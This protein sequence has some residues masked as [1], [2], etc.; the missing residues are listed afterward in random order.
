[1]KA[2]PA[3][4]GLI[5]RILRGAAGVAA[6]AALAVGAWQ[7]YRAVLAQPFRQ[8]VFT[9]D[10]DRLSHRELDALTRAIQSA[11]EGASLA[12]VRDAA[13]RVPWVRDASVR[14]KW[15]DT[16]EIRF[17]THQAFATWNG[18]QLVS[19]RGVV[20]SAEGAGPLP[21]LAGPDGAAPL[22]VE[23]YPQLARALEPIGSPLVQL[24]LSPRGG[25]QAR[26]ASGLVLELGRA[27]VLARAERFA[28][29]WPGVAA[30]GLESMHADLRYPS[31]FAVKRSVD[32]TTG[33]RPR[34]KRTADAGKPGSVPR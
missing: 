31:G 9:G 10:V 24:T 23:R 34:L 8:V 13:R 25:W 3:S 18:E 2:A 28:A 22:M 12:A 16:V 32:T 19:D 5:R 4:T 17:H 33:D 11:P 15:P 20:F 29:A 7:G 14:R 6:A 26:L 1:M 27:D 21:R 30:Q